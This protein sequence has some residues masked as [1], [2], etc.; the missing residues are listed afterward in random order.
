MKSLYWV[1]LFSRRWDLCLYWMLKCA[2]S[3][4]QD[5]LT[6]SSSCGEHWFPMFLPENYAKPKKAAL[7]KVM[8]L[9]QTTCIQCLFKGGPHSS[10]VLPAPEF[11]LAWL[12]AFVATML[13]FISSPYQSCFP[14]SFTDSVP[15][16]APNETPACISLAQ[17][18][19]PKSPILQRFLLILTT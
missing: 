16:S 4:P 5:Q 6:L 12:K 15:E 17:N 9:L 3:P 14:Y 1:I 2:K 8:V 7:L 13:K 19:F 18:L 10:T 11:C